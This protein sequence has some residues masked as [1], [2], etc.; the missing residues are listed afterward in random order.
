[1]SA[2]KILDDNTRSSLPG[3]FV[4]LSDGI[5]HYELGGP[6]SSHCIILICGFMHGFALLICHGDS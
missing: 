2:K 6:E 5:V 3:T 4:Q 1:M